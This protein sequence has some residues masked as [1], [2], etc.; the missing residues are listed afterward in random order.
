[1]ER[2]AAAFGIDPEQ[3][4]KLVEAKLTESTI[5]EFERFDALFS[6]IDTAKTKEFMKRVE[7]ETLNPF[8]A[9]IKADAFLRKFILA[10][11]FD[12]G[13]D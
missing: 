3:L 10:G 1:M 11:G 12:I 6:T 13:E 9:R 4:G 8:K 2:C 7:G 5:N